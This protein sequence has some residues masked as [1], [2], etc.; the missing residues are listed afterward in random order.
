MTADQDEP[1]VTAVVAISTIER[2]LGLTSAASGSS[3]CL[4]WSRVTSPQ[5]PAEHRRVTER[6]LVVPPIRTALD[7]S[8]Q[9]LLPD[10]VL[11]HL[12]RDARFG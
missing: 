8:L 11:E 12:E 10:T 1:D 6:D 2:V 3:R 9:A 5:Q 7:V 4:I